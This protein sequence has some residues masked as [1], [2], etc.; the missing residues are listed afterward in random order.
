MKKIFLSISV[1]GLFVSIRI[2]VNGQLASNR[3]HSFEKYG[4]SKNR[5]SGNFSRVAERVSPAVVR[6][7]IKSYKDVSDERWIGI[8]E[9]F[10]AMFFYNNMDYQVFYN[11]K[12]GWLSTIRSYNED[13]MPQD[14]RHIVKSNYYDYNINRV[15]EIEMPFNA[16]IY[17]IQLLGKTEIINL[18]VSDGEMVELQKFKRSK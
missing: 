13:Q 1:L 7:F 9:G 15:H 16:I 11:K 8:K 12:G 10:V 17:A 2:S 14:I 4:L 18:K 3:L 6:N 5:N